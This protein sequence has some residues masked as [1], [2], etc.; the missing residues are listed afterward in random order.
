M[1]QF[2]KKKVISQKSATDLTSTNA[3]ITKLEQNECKVTYYEIITGTSGSLTIPTGATINAGEFGLSGNSV[4]SKIDGSNKPT[5]ESPK[6]A[7]G[8]VV[9]ANLATDGT[10]ITS[11]TYTDASVAL[12]YSVNISALNYSNLNN[13]YIIET[14]DINGDFL[15]KNNN[16]S[17]IAN[18][19]TARNNLGDWDFKLSTGDQSTTS[20]V[21]S[22]ITDLVFTPPTV[23]K[24]Y[25]FHGILHIGCTSNGGVKFQVT[26]PTGATIWM[27]FEGLN[28]SSTTRTWS[29][30][31]TSATLTANAVCATNSAASYVVVSGEVQMGATSGNIQFG[32]ASGVNTQTST[33][34][35]LGSLLTIKQLD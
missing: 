11:G 5:Y 1:T 29:P 24:R 2:S 28:N 22:N 18:P 31:T 23:N 7:G 3:R 30:I 17:D 13:F 27:S 35:Q 12:I 25:S 14:S 10:W 15:N 33:I 34:Y 21:A 4:L 32:F 8:V 20:N 26:I 6:T 9:T 19:L 16:L